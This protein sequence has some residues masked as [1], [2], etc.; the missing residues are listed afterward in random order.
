MEPT[1]TEPRIRST[2]AQEPSTTPDVS[3]VI[4]IY[5][6]EGILSASIADLTEKIATTPAL[7]DLTFEII[8]AENGSVDRTVDV[9]RSL[10]ERHP[11]LRMVHL[12]RPDYGLALREGI[13]SAR[14]TYV[15]SDEIDLCD[16]D[17]YKRALYRLREEGYD[18][19]V[20]SKA[21]E[22]SF[23]KRPPYRRVA[24]HVINRMLRVMVG[25]RGTDTHGLKAFKRDSLL[26]IVRK[27]V[28]GRDLFASELVI[29]TQRSQLRHTEIPV[30]VIEKRKPSIQLMKRVP[31]VLKNLVR[32]TWEVR[33][34][35]P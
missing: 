23:D 35:N 5:N 18:L 7:A 1:S 34:K 6:E 16:V 19:V 22:R 27:C 14:G 20:G 12:D 28:I 15:I 11:E 9:A 32:L 10:M 13:L 21:L 8:L 17:F 4:P 2:R 25:F 26:P 29:R 3:V 30:E 31:N 24:T 33:F